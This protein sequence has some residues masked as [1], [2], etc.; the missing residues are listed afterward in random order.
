MI[1]NNNNTNAHRATEKS[2]VLY[3]TIDP[4]FHKTFYLCFLRNVTHV[5]NNQAVISS[6]FDKIHR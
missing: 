4:S 5:I 6:P 2:P 3:Y 1:N